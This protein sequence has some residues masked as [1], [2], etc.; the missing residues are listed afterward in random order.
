MIQRV[1]RCLARCVLQKPRLDV[2]GVGGVSMTDNITKRLHSFPYNG[3]GLYE[4]VDSSN[5]PHAGLSTIALKLGLKAPNLAPKVEVGVEEQLGAAPGGGAALKA[6]HA[7]QPGEADAP[8][9][10]RK[11]KYAKEAW[12]GRK[13][14]GTTHSFLV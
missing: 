5:N 12:P 2:G 13:P 1:V 6:G 7:A 10:P 4:N 9:E 3:P 11:K 8:P 14:T